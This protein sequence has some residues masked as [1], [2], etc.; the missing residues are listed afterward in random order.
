MGL[1]I[2]MRIIYNVKHRYVIHLKFGDK[3]L[4][5]LNS[6]VSARRENQYLFRNKKH[7]F[8]IAVNFWHFLSLS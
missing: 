1:S 7:N 8:Y 2:R 4:T 6:L 3:L 5:F